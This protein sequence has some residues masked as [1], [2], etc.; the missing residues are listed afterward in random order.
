M[1]ISDGVL[2]YGT[3]VLNSTT[4]YMYIITVM[5]IQQQMNGFS[6]IYVYHSGKV[7]ELS[8]LQLNS[9][10]THVNCLH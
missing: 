4:V 7:V 6:V 8:K 2:G 9:A 1:N 5:T 10:L 3:A